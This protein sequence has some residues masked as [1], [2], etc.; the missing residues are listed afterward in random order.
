MFLSHP[1]SS[2]HFA[3]FEHIVRLDSTPEIKNETPWI[4]RLQPTARA[5]EPGRLVPSIPKRFGV[6]IEGK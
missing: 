3:E 2:F 1:E 4:R 6:L 5:A